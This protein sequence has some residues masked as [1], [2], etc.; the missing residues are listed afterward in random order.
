MT[1]PM[2]NI[3]AR[4]LRQGGR[5]LATGLALIA[6]WTLAAACHITDVSNPDIVP[7]GG[8]NDPLALPTIR[9]GAIGDFGIAYTGSGAQGSGGT[10]E[11]QVLASGLL[12]D[13]WI[14][15][16]TFPDRVQA[17]ARQTDP[18]SG[19]FTTIFRNLARAH[20]AT[21]R[22]ADKFRQLSDTIRNTGMSEMLSLA[23]FT[24][25]FFAENYCSGVP[26][27]YPNPD[28]TVQYGAQNTTAQMLDSALALF[29]YA[30][31]AARQLNDSTAG[32]STEVRLALVGKARTLLDM[33]RIADAD[34]TV[35]AANVP[36]TFQYSILHDLNTTRQQ[37]GV[38]S[39]IRKFKRYGVANREGGVGIPWRDTTLL[40]P[41]TPYTRTGNP[42]RT[43]VGFDNV[44][45]QYDQLRYV[46]EK[47][48]IT[49]ATGL[50]ARLINAEAALL[51]GD[52]TGY[53]NLLNALRA[54]PPTYILAGVQWTQAPTTPP[55]P[56]PA[57][58]LAPLAKP[59][60]DTAA[61][62]LLF[63]ERAR[64]LWATGHRLNDMRRLVRAT[65]VRGGYGRAEN[66]VFPNGPYFKN[67]LTYGKD[68]NF[69]IPLDES[70]NPGVT[71]CLDRLP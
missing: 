63:N 34:T 5:V 65:G 26:L 50:E 46:D 11:G 25:L 17:D 31:T 22:A 8:L 27:S 23:A 3:V 40:D 49:L 66:S 62:N 20:L 6:A 64:W 9:A 47:A 54:S 68:V 58:A 36:T 45:P 67:G 33:G 29:D 2:L 37:N 13:E 35:S 21:L 14:N 30:L 18:A 4:A 12:G 70:N 28:G 42:A 10:T 1:I 15:T 16:E 39:G 51:R 48:A 19:T 60:S 24:R 55:N 53:L 52:T 61:V 38:Y 32:K 7:T 57:G 41:R 69:P 71:G 43:N 59:T 56:I 44:T